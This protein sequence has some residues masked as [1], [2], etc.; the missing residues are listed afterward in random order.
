MAELKEIGAYDSERA[1]IAKVKDYCNF[2]PDVTTSEGYE[3]SK[4]V[5]LDVGKILTSVEARRKELK[6]D[7]IKTGQAIDSEA[8]TIVEE[9]AGLQLP[10]KAAYKELDNLKK[11]A[12]ANRKASL[13][14]RIEDM[15]GLPVFLANETSDTICDAMD[16]VVENLCLDY[17]E[18][19][20]QS[21]KVR[22]DTITA[23]EELFN[24]KVNAEKDAAELAVL[25]E[26]AAAQKLIDDEAR[27]RIEANQQAQAKIDKAENAARDAAKAIKQAEI[28]KEATAKATAQAAQA[29]KELS[30]KLIRDAAD[31]AAQE[32]INKTQREAKEAADIIEA[33]ESNN[34]HVGAI[35]KAAKESIMG[36]GFNECDAKK[37]VMAIHAGEIENIV[38]NY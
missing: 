1:Q 7:S 2:L 19:G 33:R 35:R 12:E 16:G 32:Q 34:R 8:K 37:L 21:M 23:L 10:H 18:Y 3:K 31:N 30:D 17:D 20:N 13:E 11:E 28:D 22:N 36:L 38:I 24:L 14:Q 25:R 26:A 15:R 29:A 4:R 6:S 9:L 27:I 5:S